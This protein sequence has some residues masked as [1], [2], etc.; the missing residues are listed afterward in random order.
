MAK[1]KSQWDRYKLHTWKDGNK[2][3]ARNDSDAK[4]YENKVKELKNAR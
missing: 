3:K 1:N 2:S 4:L